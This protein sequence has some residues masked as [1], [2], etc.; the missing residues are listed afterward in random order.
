MPPR[1]YESLEAYRRAHALSLRLTRL[2]NRL[3]AQ[4]RF[5]LASQLRRAA[6]S[7]PANLAEGK[8]AFGPAIYLRHVQVALGSIAEVDYFLVCVRDEGYVQPGECEELADEA[9]KV[10]GLMVLLAVSLRKAV[11]RRK[12]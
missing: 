5:E 4:E 12:A 11:A 6:R 10:R 3:P 9:W 1:P 8:G 2:C 7:V